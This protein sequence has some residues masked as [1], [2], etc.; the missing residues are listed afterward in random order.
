MVVLKFSLDPLNIILLNLRF[1]NSI[2]Y[3]ANEASL[4]N[5]FHNNNHF[6]LL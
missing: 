6:Y 2:N 3:V 4:S 5:T 1:G